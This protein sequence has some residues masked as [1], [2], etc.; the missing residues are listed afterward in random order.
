MRIET[1]KEDLA[2][3]CRDTLRQLSDNTMTPM[4]LLSLDR[5]SHKDLELM[6][7]ILDEAHDAL[8][9]LRTP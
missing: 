2:N 7:A 9:K 8:K 4:F 1:T 5:M 3:D 6:S